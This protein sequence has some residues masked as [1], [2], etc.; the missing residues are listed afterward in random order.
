MQFPR[1]RRIAAALAVASTAV[2]SVTAAAPPALGDEGV[3]FRRIQFPV[4]GSVRYSDDF[5]APRSGG[6]THEGNDLMGAKLQPLLAAVDGR[7]S[8]RP[9]SGGLSGN[10]VTVTDDDGWSYRYIHVNNDTPGTDDNANPPEWILAPGVTSGMRVKAG[11]HIAFMGDSGNA[12]DTAPHLHFEIRTPDGQAVDPW[13][14]LRL[15]QG[16]RAGNR[17]SYGTNPPAVPSAKGG[18]GYWVL[19]ADGGVF[20]FGAAAFHGSTGNLKLSQPV[21]G[22]AATPTGEGYWLVARDGGIFA[23]GDAGF[24]G[25]TGAIRLNRPI[26]GMAATPTGRG[27]WLVASD[28]GIF[29]FGD[30]AFAG[31]TGAMTLNQPI[32]GMAPSADGGYW[33]VAADGGIFAFGDASFLGSVPSVGVRTSVVSIAATPTGAGY[34]LLA[35]DG[36]VYAFGDAR[37]VGS[38]PGSG[39]CTWPAG[40]RLVPTATGKGYWIQARD[41]STWQFGDARFLGSLTAAGVAA[42]AAAV[43]LAPLPVPPPPPAPVITVPPVTLPPVTVPPV[44]WP[45]WHH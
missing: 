29:A 35:A 15:A 42:N 19:G 30:A 44:T 1:I 27:Y 45:G 22:M 33:L 8:F 17:C 7:L 43:D 12:E 13:T 37:F 26:V 28:G 18:T 5:G 21:V 41:G 34:W 38:L 20:G 16:L 14:S 4:Q 24:F 9:D 40:V 25:S 32:V 11:Q 39:L 6:R 3:A 2:A 10:M 23:F 31:S 36:G